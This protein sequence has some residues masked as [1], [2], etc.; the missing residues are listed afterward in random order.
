LVYDGGAPKRVSD[1]IGVEKKMSGRVL[2]RRR[3]NC[4]DA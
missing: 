2:K 1:I 4:G 3:R